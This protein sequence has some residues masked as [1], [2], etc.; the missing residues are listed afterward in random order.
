MAAV[1]GGTRERLLEVAREILDE[2]GFE[3]LTL[4]Q[5]AKRA[6]VS[7]AAP[8]RHFPNLA[9]L[10]AAVAA[11]GF[12]QLQKSVE[13]HTTGIADS[14][15]RLA[16]ATHG[17]VAFAMANPGAFGLMFRPERYDTSDPAYVECGLAAF[18]Q[19]VDLVADAQR[20]GWR[21]SASAVD[22]ATIAWSAVHGLTQL[23]LHGAVQGATGREDLSPL[24]TLMT[25]VLLGPEEKRK[26]R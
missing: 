12:V 26:R 2:D 19:L 16:A 20:D 18:G 10:L 23:W 5:I 13:E 9:S 21:E 3:G 4:R 24:L 7:H 15:A 11:D 8:A 14:R 17:Y 22:L 25:E 6:G 1:E